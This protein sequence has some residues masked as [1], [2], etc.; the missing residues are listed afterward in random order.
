MILNDPN[1]TYVAVTSENRLKTRSITES[2]DTHENFHG[3]KVW[4]VSFFDINPVGANDKF[5]YLENTGT[6]D[7]AISDV[8]MSCTT[9]TGRMYIKKVTGTPTFTAGADLT[10]ISRN[11]SK[12]PNL[13]ATVKSDTDITGLT[14][15][16]TIFHME[17]DTVDKLFHL[18]TS[19]LIIVGP[20]KAVALEWAAATGEV[21]GVVSV[22]ELPDQDDV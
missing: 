9:T 13:T 7:L 8:R 21:S 14:D 20:G 1:G 10:P 3:G 19:S 18:S 22:M 5:F 6:K 12:S 17:L 15:D 4:S 2:F 16:G 11:L